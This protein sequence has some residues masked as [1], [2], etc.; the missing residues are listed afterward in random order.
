MT[1]FIKETWPVAI[2]AKG[3][4]FSAPEFRPTPARGA[5]T[6][7]ADWN[8]A[9]PLSAEPLDPR[10][11]TQENAHLRRLLASMLVENAGLKRRLALSEASNRR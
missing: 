6:H 11:L 5:F 1:V 10:S 7:E 4:E 8:F 3:T 9:R 2:V